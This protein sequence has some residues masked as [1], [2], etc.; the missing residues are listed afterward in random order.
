MIKPTKE[1]LEIFKRTDGA[2]SV[3]E[4]IEIMNIAAQTP[5]GTYIELGSYKGKS[6]MSALQWLGEGVF[7]LVD[8]EFSDT[9][10]RADAASD[11]L[12]TV[13]EETQIELIFI[14]D[15]SINYL[16]SRK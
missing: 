7:Y 15:Y 8:P 9:K 4:S 3:T 10:F 6:A 14:S 1:F 5:K 11:I 2:L 12:S 13:S 16:P